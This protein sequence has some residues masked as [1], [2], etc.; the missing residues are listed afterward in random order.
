MQNLMRADFGS[1][2]TGRVQ[3][4]ILHWQNDFA[5]LEVILSQETRVFDE[6]H[7]VPTPAGH[8]L[9]PWAPSNVFHNLWIEM[10]CCMRQAM[11]FNE[12][13]KI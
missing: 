7:G 12:I 2:R 6:F 3:H 4:L 9:K 10:R 13:G 5:F 8:G 1:L 11:T